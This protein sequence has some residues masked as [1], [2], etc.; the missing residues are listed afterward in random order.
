MSDF[1]IDIALHERQ[2]DALLSEANEILYGGAAGGGK[3]MLMRCASVL[4]CAEISGLNVYLFR[5]LSDDLYKNHM[6]GSGNYMEILG[7]WIDAGHVKWNGSKNYWQFWNGSKIWL[8]HCQYEKDVI[9]YQGAEI[10]MLLIDE[11]THFTEM[12]Y[13]YLRARCRLGGLI[14]PPKYLGKF[15]FI[16]S[17]SNPG[18]VGHTWVRRTFVNFAAPMLTKRASKQDGGMLRA[19]IPAKLEDNPTMANDPMYRERLEGLGSKQLVKAML[20][21]DWNI[22]AGGAL[23]DVWVTEKVQLPRFAIPSQWTVDRSFDWGSAHPFSVGWW[24][25]ANGEEV[26]LEDGGTLCLP[27]GSLIRIDEWYGT[28]EIG[29]NQGLKMSARDIA[30]G[31][32]AREKRMVDEGWIK[33][34]PIAGPADNQIYNVNEKESDSIASKMAEEGVEWTTSDKRAGSRING[35][36]LLRDRLKASISR[37]GA[38]IYFM[39]HCISM[40]ETLPV[41]PRDTKNIE[42]VDTN[43][44]DHPYDEVR[45]KVLANVPKPAKTIEVTTA[46]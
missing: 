35:L 32:N 29:T 44:E 26:E 28:K 9:K 2:T 15:P 13:R 34:L 31:I 30:K 33:S 12:I 3:S 17:G 27:A 10:H 7:P 23:D 1:D 21:G 46:Y 40:F 25:E 14:I 41:L 38:G 43:A 19:F 11:L 5:R 24:A 4:Y 20:D 42:D 8:C 37:E 36:Q 18:G 45:Y 39:E 6:T 16:L 22:V